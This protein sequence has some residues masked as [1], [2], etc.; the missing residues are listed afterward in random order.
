MLQ[1]IWSEREEMYYERVSQF[2]TLPSLHNSIKIQRLDSLPKK[3]KIIYFWLCIVPLIFLVWLARDKLF[4]W[5]NLIVYMFYYNS[6]INCGRSIWK[7]IYYT[8][9]LVKKLGSWCL[10]ATRITEVKLRWSECS[11]I[12]KVL[13]Y[14]K[15]NP[16]SRW[17]TFSV[18]FHKW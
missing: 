18:S 16:A 15:I 4:E 2:K 13:D 12:E 17:I 14:I 7:Y 3:H 10:R 1:D 8:Y 11:A 9:S 5:T 6:A